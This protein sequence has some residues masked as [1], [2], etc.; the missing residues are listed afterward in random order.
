MTVP[1]YRDGNALQEQVQVT[2]G[3]LT[4]L[5]ENDWVRARRGAPIR[6]FNNS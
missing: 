1:R 4:A 6:L 5:D 2:F 3:T